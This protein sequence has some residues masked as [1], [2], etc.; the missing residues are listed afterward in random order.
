MFIDVSFSFFVY[1]LKH[2]VYWTTYFRLRDIVYRG[3][4]KFCCFAA[5]CPHPTNLSGFCKVAILHSSSILACL[6]LPVMLLCCLSARITPL[7]KYSDKIPCGD[8]FS[9]TLSIVYIIFCISFGST[10]E[11]LYRYDVRPI[12]HLLRQRKL[13]VVA[14]VRNSASWNM[15][16][17]S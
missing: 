12:Y 13:F 16:H 4:F 2:R 8:L 7:A 15:F 1:P 17:E 5:T 10:H 9:A 11:K 3:I 14:S 6:H